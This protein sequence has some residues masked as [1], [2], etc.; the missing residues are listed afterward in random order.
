MVS[1]GIQWAASIPQRA[2]VPSKSTGWGSSGFLLLASGVDH[3]MIC[4]HQHRPDRFTAVTHFA[5]AQRLQTSVRFVCG[6][7]QSRKLRRCKASRWMVID[8]FEGSVRLQ[9]Q[10]HTNH[11]RPL[12]L[13]LFG[14]L[15][16]VRCLP[17]VLLSHFLWTTA[18]HLQVISMLSEGL[19]L[20][21]LLSLAYSLIRVNGQ[22]GTS[23]LF[24]MNSKAVH[25]FRN[26][27]KVP[28]GFEFRNSPIEGPFK[29]LLKFT[30]PLGQSEEL[31]SS[32]FTKSFS[33]KSNRKI[34]KG[35]SFQFLTG[36]LK[37]ANWRV[38]IW[39]LHF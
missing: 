3:R 6:A 24:T 20:L 14:L 8:A 34:S 32:M 30:V 9:R 31:N 39:D 1:S 13:D 22:S 17:F 29:F 2:Y 38:S 21:L 35:S 26:L 27:A 11:T 36:K 19:L 5:Y 4:I 37:A 16:S 15:N 33:C 25:T 18:K 10:A 12:Y 23:L 7:S 28:Y